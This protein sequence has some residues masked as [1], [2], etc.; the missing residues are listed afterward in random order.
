MSSGYLKV[1]AVT[2]RGFVPV[3]DATVTVRA[4]GDGGMTLLHVQLTDDSGQTTPIR[5]DT[6]ERSDS[7]SPDR[8]QGWTDVIVTVSHPDYDSVTVRTVQIFPGVTTL[9]EAVMIPRGAA[10]GD[11]AGNEIFDV[12]DQGL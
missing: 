2:S 6:P 11:P 9:L 3:A 4:Q 5:I 8:E 7:L 12:P 10:P 1:Q